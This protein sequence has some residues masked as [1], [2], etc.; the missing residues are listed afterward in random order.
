MSNYKTR[1]SDTGPWREKHL[2]ANAS[3]AKLCQIPQILM[4]DNGNVIRL[5]SGRAEVIADVKA[6]A[7]VVDGKQLIPLLVKRLKTEISS[8]ITGQFFHP[9]F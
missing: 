9:L 4:P 1:Y 7:L 2:R 6:D 3:I 8:Y 5:C